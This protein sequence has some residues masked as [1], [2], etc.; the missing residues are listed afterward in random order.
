MHLLSTS[1]PGDKSHSKLPDTQQDDTEGL[2]DSLELYFC[3]S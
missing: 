2:A 3:A 1:L